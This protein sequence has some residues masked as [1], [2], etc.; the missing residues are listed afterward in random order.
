KIF[1]FLFYNIFFLF[2]TGFSQDLAT[3]PYLSIDNPNIQTDT[4]PLVYDMRTT[5]RLSPV[6]TQPSWAC[7]ASAALSSVESLWRTTG[8]GNYNLSDI[9]LKL[10]HGFV[11]KRSKNGNHY[12]ATAYFSRRSGPIEKSAALDS[13]CYQEIPKVAYI[14]D[15]RYLPNDPG[16]IKQVLLN[17]GAV[18]SMM[19]FDE[20]YFDDST[21][22]YYYNDTLEINHVIN[23]IGWNDT[24]STAG[25]KGAWIIQNSRGKDFGENGFFYISYNDVNI[26]QFNAIWPK[27]MEYDT[28]ST[29]YYYDTL[30]SY[31]SYGFGNSIA[32]GL[33]KFIAP[34]KQEITKIG[35]SVNYG[36]SKIEIKIYDDFNDSTKQLSNRLAF[37]NEQVCRFPGYYTFDLPASFII[38]K[39]D[40][41]FISVKYNTPSDTIPIPVEFDIKGYSKPK[42]QTKKCWI[43]P[44]ADKWPNAW[45]ELGKESP[46]PFL[47]FNLCIKA[48]GKDIMATP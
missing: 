3:E 25:G 33:V 24:L 15:A 23:I 37:L 17:Y 40:D 45:Y 12:M 21:N 10:C 30:G 5:E 27:W 35:T 22:T 13:C 47:Q 42:I 18:F 29:V 2:I 16:I 20:K 46:F 8:F 4:F 19:Y 32:Y 14:T 31:R 34:R 7:W 9:N 11:P 26:L 48:Y 28:N 44:N 36:N 6:K 1:I 39:N 38:A 41:F 43:N